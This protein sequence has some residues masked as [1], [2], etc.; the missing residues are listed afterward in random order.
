[1]RQRAKDGRRACGVHVLNGTM[2]CLRL[3]PVLWAATSV[4]VAASA[5][6][7]TPAAL[8]D[9]DYARAERLMPYNTVP[10]VLHSVSDVTWLAD[11]RLSYRVSTAGGSELILIDPARGT[12]HTAPDQT[13]S[14]Q[15]PTMAQSPDGQWAAFIRD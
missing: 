14:A 12:R 15:T 4:L 5:V 1:H 10:L 9:A 7:G 8:T 11:G 13:P 3:R 2:S 6:A